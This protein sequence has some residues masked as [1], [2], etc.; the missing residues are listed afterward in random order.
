MLMEAPSDDRKA[1]EKAILKAHKVTNDRLHGDASI[2]SSSSGT[3]SITVL[4][5]GR[6]MYVNNEIGRAH[7]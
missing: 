3:T 4:L 1:T 7:V 6:T 2:D 5:K